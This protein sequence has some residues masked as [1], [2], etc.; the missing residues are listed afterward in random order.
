MDGIVLTPLKQIDNPNGDIFHIMK[1][2]DQ[3]FHDFGEAYFSTIHKDLIK[4]WKKH[5]Q[6]VLNLVVPVGAIEFV[7]YNEKKNEFFNIILSKNNYQRLT[8]ASGLWVAFRGIDK[9]NILLN[10]A[11]IEHDPKE[12]ESLALEEINYEW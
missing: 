1:K 6:M 7:I 11:S 4:G 9:H 5:N 2:S 12:S 10:I 3:G 8:V